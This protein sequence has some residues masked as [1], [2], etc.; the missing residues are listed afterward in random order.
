MVLD[1]VTKIAPHIA[2]VSEKLRPQVLLVNSLSKTYSMTGW[3]IGSLVGDK[4][5]VDA[6]SNY[7]SQS[8]SCAV[9]FAQKAAVEALRGTQKTVEDAM[10]ELRRRRDVAMKA[11]S[12]FPELKMDPPAGAFF[13][14]VPIEKSYGKVITVN[15]ESRTITNSADFA[16]ALL[17]VEGVATVPGAEFGMD[18][19]IRL[20]YT[21]AEK[22]LLEGIKRLGRFIQ[23]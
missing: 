14:W 19:Y 16:T 15:G 8:A 21:V 12:E 1:G 13:L 2:Q 18:G 10:K 7:Q 6:C 5:I 11:L 4:R 3:R 9:S 20:S 22:K 17:D 23:S